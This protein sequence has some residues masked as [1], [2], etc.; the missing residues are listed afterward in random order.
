M[1]NITALILIS[2]LISGIGST[3]Q[4]SSS[5]IVMSDKLK[6]SVAGRIVQRRFEQYIGKYLSFTHTVRET[7]NT[8]IGKLEKINIPA[9]PDREFNAVFSEVRGHTKEDNDAIHALPAQVSFTNIVTDFASNTP[10]QQVVKSIIV[11]PRDQL[12]N[13][14]AADIADIIETDYV[15]NATGKGR[16]LATYTKGGNNYYE[17]LIEKITVQNKGGSPTIHTIRATKEIEPLVVML[18]AEEIVV[19]DISA[20]TPQERPCSILDLCK[21]QDASSPSHTTK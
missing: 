2:A 8:F 16:L 19:E 1:I 12:L 4:A 10:P 11:T 7:T 17:V 21:W 5:A 3:L 9:A 14:L 20:L 18:D 6:N 15:H 13:P